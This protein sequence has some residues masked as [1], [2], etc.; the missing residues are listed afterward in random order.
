MRTNRTTALGVG[1]IGVG[2]VGRRHAELIVRHKDAHLVGLFDPQ[3]EAVQQVAERLSAT[4]SPS[5]DSLLEDPTVSAVV[6]ASPLETH[7]DIVSLCAAAG[8]DILC[9]KPL[10]GSVSECQIAIAAAER[11]RVRLTVGFMR[12]YDP[13]YAEAKRQIEAGTI[14]IPRYIRATSRDQSPPEPQYLTSSEAAN[15][16]LE[17]AVHDFDLCRWLFASEPVSVTATTASV[18]PKLPAELPFDLGLA[19]VRFANGALA[20]VENYKF[21][22]YGYDIR[23]E[24]VGDQGS[25]FIG[26]QPGTGAGTVLTAVDSSLPQ[27][28]VDRFATAYERQM[29]DWIERTIADREPFVSGLDGLAATA[30][31]E[32]ADRSR[33][34]DGGESV[35]ASAIDPV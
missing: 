2:A 22:R 27:H 18:N 9:E 3:T 23:T 33:R 32:A 7:A 21:A 35:A 13:Q 29:D 15:P 31:A 6:V 8:K 12:R 20:D 4:A 19:T 1:V 11:A 17:S 16:F 30:I 14:G 26:A 34:Y 24:I 5:I 28:W 25:I 10:A